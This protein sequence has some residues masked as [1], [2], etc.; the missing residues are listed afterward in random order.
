MRALRAVFAVACGCVLWSVA[1]CDQDY[2]ASNENREPFMDARAA[3]PPAPVTSGSAAASTAT[4][5]A[6]ATAAKPTH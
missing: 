2:A 1:A 4:A 5:T 6:T 3:T